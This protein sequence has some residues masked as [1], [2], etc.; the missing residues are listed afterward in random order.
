MTPAAALTQA[1][2]DVTPAYATDPAPGSDVAHPIELTD[3]EQLQADEYQSTGKKTA[4]E[5]ATPA[6]WKTGGFTI[7]SVDTRLPFNNENQFVPLSKVT[8]VGEWIRNVGNGSDETPESI[9]FKIDS[10]LLEVKEIQNSSGTQI[11]AY[12]DVASYKEVLRLDNNSDDSQKTAV[13]E[14]SYSITA[15]APSRVVIPETAELGVATPESIA[16]SVEVYGVDGKPLAYGTGKDY[17]VAVEK[18]GTSTDLNDPTN[19][20]VTAP[21]DTSC[22]VDVLVDLKNPNYAFAPAST[23]G[24]GTVTVAPAS[25]NTA[26]F[27]T[28][29]AVVGTSTAITASN[30]G[31]DADVAW[32]KTATEIDAAVRGSVAVYPEDSKTP[33]DST[34]YTISY[35]DESGEALVK[36]DGE[37]ADTPSLPGRYRVLVTMDDAEDPLETDLTLDVVASLAT[38]VEYTLGSVKTNKTTPATFQLVWDKTLTSTDERVADVLK[39]LEG[40]KATLDG[41]S[42]PVSN[43]D[44]EFKVSTVAD[45]SD[46]TGKITVSPASNDGF[47][48]G[49]FDIDYKYG[50]TLPEFSLNKPS[51][52]YNTAGYTVSQLITAPYVKNSDGTSTQLT[53]GAG[54]ATDEYEVVATY[55]DADGKTQTVLGANPITAV[56][57]YKIV[58]TGKGQYAGTQTFDFSITPRTV[59]QKEVDWVASTSGLTYDKDTDTWHATF[60]AGDPIEPAPSF[61]IPMPGDTPVTSLDNKATASKDDIKAGKWDYEVA[62]DNNK[63]AG[64]ATATVTF[65]GNYSGT[66]ELPFEIDPADLKKDL[67]ATAT[68]QNQLEKDFPDKPT[69]E[70]VKG[71]AITYVN[72][73]RQTVTLKEGDYAVKSLKRVG[74]TNTKGETT[75]EFVAEGQGNYAGEVTGTFKTVADSM[76]IAALWDAE[77]AE[78]DYF[79]RMGEPV[80]ADVTVKTKPTSTKPAT[81][82]AAKDYKVVYANDTEAGTATATVVGA[83]QYAG[84]I[85]LTYEVAPLQISQESAADVKLKQAS[86]DYVPGIEAKPEIDWNASKITPVNEGYEA[87][88]IALNLLI[89]DVEITYADNDK[90]GTAKAVVTGKE[91]GN[92]SGSYAVDFAIKP[93]DLAKAEV[94]GPEAPVAPGTSLADAI[95][96]TYQGQAVDAADYTAASEDAVPGAASVTVTG[97]GNFTGTNAADVTVLYDVAGLDYQVSSG[98]Y[99]GQSQTP[100][101]TASYD[102]DGKKVAVDAKAY[103]LAAGK[104]VDAGTY[105]VPVTGDEAQGWGGATTVAFT[106]SK[107]AGPKAATVTYTDAGAPVVT[108]PGLTEGKD[109]KVTPNPAQKKLVVTYTGNYTGS[110]TVD[111]K[112][113]GG[114]DA[115]VTPGAAG[116]TGWVGS[117]NDWAYYENGQAVK[118][119][120]KSIGGE[121]YH[122]EKSGKMT[123]TKWFQDTDGEW[124][125]LN[126]SHKG[127]Y[128]AML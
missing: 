34:F 73:A 127:S 24:E 46:A 35:A 61:N 54:N 69:V 23:D 1:A 64:D 88:P 53:T 63:N 65:H 57:D 122:F 104:Y 33:I 70:D 4:T 28:K 109:F 98:T 97:K 45:T 15:V 128:G 14:L 20:S 82:V 5:D 48:T 16:K 101:V 50:T 19:G 94:A 2:M 40:M 30:N 49:S 83:G 106:I 44:L 117:G 72:D 100:V 12:K 43:D 56:G 80:P 111:Y 91:G 31:A 7:S 8:V 6:D 89:N 84:S 115:P 47:Y 112:P 103:D 118:G 110:T 10:G 3:F 93:A 52:A 29:D 60:D 81:A 58:V 42:T 41:T 18:A 96:V 66:V 32:S 107:A 39:Q 90:A 79:Y 21:I 9:F 26:K 74:S 116:K 95:S 37:T 75:Y 114:T 120:W 86:F 27:A 105:Q 102:A 13:G 59:A 67:K 119:G 99:N 87:G 11:S 68:A 78:G 85:E 126:Q 123:N 121:W 71:V 125:L 62:Y 17:T 38:D 77:I 22:K 124:Y 36:D 51:E 108:I 55:V 76:D 25:T 113:V 92:V